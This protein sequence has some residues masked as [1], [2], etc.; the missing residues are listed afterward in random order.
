M[1]ARALWHRMENYADHERLYMVTFGADERNAARANRDPKRPLF[2][3]FEK[4]RQVPARDARGGTAG[5]DAFDWD[6]F[7]NVDEEAYRLG[8]Q[9]LH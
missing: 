4:S 2:L 8:S 9:V 1:R 7:Y 5:A 3:Y 6:P